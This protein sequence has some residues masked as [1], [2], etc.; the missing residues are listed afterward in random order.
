L[1]RILGE[2][3]IQLN[4]SPFTKRI[5]QKHGIEFGAPKF[6]LDYTFGWKTILTNKLVKLTI[7]NKPIKGD[8]N[9]YCFLDQNKCCRL[10]IMAFMGLFFFGELHWIAKEDFDTAP[11]A[12]SRN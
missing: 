10:P 1:K 8:L 2:K 9:T 4:S 11:V 5:T 12:A 6:N 3:P 7:L